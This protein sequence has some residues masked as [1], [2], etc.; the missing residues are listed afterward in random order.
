MLSSIARRPFR[1]LVPGA[2]ALAALLVVVALGDRRAPMHA[3]Q[4]RPLDVTGIGA[5]LEPEVGADELVSRARAFLHDRGI[6]TAGEF[7]GVWPGLD[8]GLI[9]RLRDRHGAA[10]VTKFAAQGAPLAPWDVAFYRPL[11]RVAH[12]AQTVV[13]LSPSGQVIG[14]E[15]WS[16]DPP[17]LRGALP[18]GWAAGAA[19]T[20]AGWLGLDPA[21]LAPRSAM[22]FMGSEIARADA[23]WELAGVRLGDARVIVTATRRG[24]GLTFS[25]QVFDPSAMPSM[26]AAAGQ[27]TA[28][29]LAIM[30]ALGLAFV[31]GVCALHAGPRPA[32]GRDIWGISAGFAG[33]A[34]LAAIEGAVLLAGADPILHVAG[35][36]FV[37][38]AVL[39]ALAAFRFRRA[40]PGAARAARW[41]RIALIA[42]V[43][44][45]F[46][47]ASMACTGFL[48]AGCTRA[49]GL[50]RYTS[51]PLAVLALIAGSR[52]A[53]L[54]A[55]AILLAATALIPNCTCGNLVNIA[56]IRWMGAS[57]MCYFA[58]FAVTLVVVLGLRGIRPR[59]CLAATAT[60]SLGV[61]IIG[62][63][64]QL[65]GFPW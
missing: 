37:L 50:V 28:Y 2:L 22:D 59:L 44:I 9:A 29:W 14:Y 43:P 36:G 55:Y 38:L 32:P 56:W 64:H 57:P 26:A 30:L 17:P 15:S 62:I 31:L 52:D 54:H 13:T 20:V 19:R 27:T 25:T 5:V 4:A 3:M 42:T 10:A 58:P 34:V 48:E 12:H 39:A 63:S 35:G 16:S 61:A 46:V 53:R 47:V 23:I 18:A 21:R 60:T 40:R 1:V 51:A 45:S 65:F 7:Y 11:E 8:E 6:D 24:D 49:C 33:G 41:V